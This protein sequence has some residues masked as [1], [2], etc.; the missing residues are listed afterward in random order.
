MRYS[1]GAYRAVRIQYIHRQSYG[2][3]ELNHMQPMP[4]YP[5]V[6]LRTY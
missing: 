2:R 3:Y 4:D 6:E 1:Q 5:L